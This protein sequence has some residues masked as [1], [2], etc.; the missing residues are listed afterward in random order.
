MSRTIRLPESVQAGQL[1]RWSGKV[2][3]Q[4]EKKHG[5]G[6]PEAAWHCEE[7]R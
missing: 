7:A 3:N 4:G 1:S 5:K 6:L 2:V